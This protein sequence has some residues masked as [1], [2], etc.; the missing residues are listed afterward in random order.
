MLSRLR[1]VPPILIASCGLSIHNRS[2]CVP[3]RYIFKKRLQQTRVP[4]M[5]FSVDTGLPGR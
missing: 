4:G 5:V 3:G 1:H 2:I